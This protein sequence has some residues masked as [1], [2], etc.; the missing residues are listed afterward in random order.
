M[1]NVSM[2]LLIAAFAVTPIWAQ[3]QAPPTAAAPAAT[4]P[5]DQQATKEQMTQLFKVM[6]LDG[7]MQETL[8]AI[9]T[10]IQ[11]Q[12]RTQMSD[13]YAN[14]PDDAQPNV[15]QKAKLND[16]LNKYLDRATHLYSTEEIMGDVLGVYQRHMSRDDV[17][18]Y[19]AF[20]STPAGQHL[21]DSKSKIMQE[22]MPLVMKRVETGSA[23]LDAAMARDAQ[24]I[25]KTPAATTA[26]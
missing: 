26:K 16:L 19:I 21:L 3:T 18:A 12:I 24:A 20:Y 5:A 22:Y 11:D 7:E 25:V 1:K 4:I 15:E 23:E 8:R 13:M 14:L 2:A 10:M 6:R 17:T 9:P